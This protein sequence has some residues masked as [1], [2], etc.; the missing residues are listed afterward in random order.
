MRVRALIRPSGTEP[1]VKAYVEV[2]APVPSAAAVAD[3]RS[4]ATALAT[5]VAV[6]LLA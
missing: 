6:A 1:K 3:A 2:V 4:K 5:R